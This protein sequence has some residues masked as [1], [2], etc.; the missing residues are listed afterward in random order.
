MGIWCSL[1]RNTNADPLGNWSIVF[2]IITVLAIVFLAR[3]SGPIVAKSLVCIRD[4]VV[5]VPLDW[6]LASILRAVLGLVHDIAPTLHEALSF[7]LSLSK[8]LRELLPP[9]RFSMLF[10]L[11][12]LLT[13][14]V[15]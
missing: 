10:G 13:Q 14:L 9:H 3:R 12:P 7:G 4:L 15:E 8:L 6:S 5:Q 11:A 1:S 2:R